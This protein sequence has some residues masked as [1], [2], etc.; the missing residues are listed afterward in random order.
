M[1][2]TPFFLA[3]ILSIFLHI[4]LIAQVEIP[5]NQTI[6]IGNKNVNVYISK[7]SKYG[8][9]AGFNFNP[10]NSS[11]GFILENGI[12]ESGGFYVD[13]DYAVIWSPGDQNRLLRVYDEDAMGGSNYEKAYI[14]ANGFY[15]QVSDGRQKKE[16]V[17]IAN[18]VD[19]FKAI[20]GVEYS[21][22]SPFDENTSDGKDE[23][24]IKE[25]K[26]IGF[27]AQEVE[28]VVPE[29]VDTDEYGNKF[30]SYLT[31]IP[32]LV[33]VCKSQQ[34]LLEV[35]EKKL[36]LQDEAIQ[37]LLSELTL[38]KEEVSKIKRK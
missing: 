11:E 7:T 14:D 8:Q 33:E 3:S 13:G 31:F 5:D 19:K 9:A 30:V 34:E 37:S 10:N 17:Q 26:Y 28:Q 36:S 32:M 35:Q 27:I 23:S 4:D 15:Y 18:S 6:K 25:K 38:L 16:I 21:Y 1:K 29:A 2:I 12:S 22:V 20:R 24:K